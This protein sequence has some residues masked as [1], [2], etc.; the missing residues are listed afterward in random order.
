MEAF[1]VYLAKAGIALAAFHLFYLLLFQ[2]Q[3][4]F[5]FN[6]IYL[7]LA[8]P[9]SYLLPL[10]TFKVEAPKFDL[11][12]MAE[13]ANP[14]QGEQAVQAAVPANWLG[15]AQIIFAAGFVIF[16]LKLLIGNIRAIA[17]VRKSEKVSLHN[18]ACCISDHDVHP[19]SFFNRIIIPREVVE[20]RHLPVILR[21]EQIHVK[22]QHTIDVFLAELLFLF[23]WFNPFA[24]LLKDA[25]RNNLEYLTDDL[26]IREADRQNYQ[27]AMVAMAD[28]DGVAPFLT[29]LNGS[30]L[31]NRI[32]MM[33]K[34]TENKKQILRKL[35]LLPLLTL[36]V[37]TLSNKEFEAAPLNQHDNVVSGVVTAAGSGKVLSG[38]SV[39]I[40][41]THTG[42]ITDTKGEFILKVA[43]FPCTL[44]F[45]FPG[46]A[47]REV[48]LE[49]PAE[50]NVTLIPDY[51]D[52]SSLTTPPSEEWEPG[53]NPLYIVDG[54]VV[55][56]IDDIDPATIESISILKSE[57]A[58]Q[59]YGDKA[60]DGVIDI[61][62]LKKPAKSKRNKKGKETGA[63]TPKAPNETVFIV[64]GKEMDPSSQPIG[65]IES[66]ETVS[67]DEADGATRQIVK[68]RSVDNDKLP[69]TNPLIVVDGE[70]KGNIDVKSLDID[71]ETIQSIDVLKDQSA[72]TLY[73]EKGK[74]GVIL[75]TTKKK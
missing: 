43:E 20:S 28:K 48:A 66:V 72:T 12:Q 6:R 32:L 71:P 39:L 22:E 58:M 10:I 13:L 37:I 54:K 25:I 7:F 68:I 33:K 16:L 55:S 52:A 35:L 34:K 11:I 30:Q 62:L 60:K 47:K 2:P 42:T 44:V 67:S 65:V 4:H 57:A 14:V 18:I 19:F 53:A 38:T 45:V 1:L 70:E 64:D 24:W 63:V 21:H 61:K 29:A 50:L 41:G 15:I 27:L 49:K 23:Q 75:I 3:K 59:L 51:S 74:A 17:L 26:I 56:S 36:L 73:G 5:R 8:M 46:F 40:K 69:K 9:V 31:K